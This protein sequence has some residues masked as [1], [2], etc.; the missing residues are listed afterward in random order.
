M[1]ENFVG[2]KEESQTT[3]WGRLNVAENYRSDDLLETDK[4]FNFCERQNDSA[5]T[6]KSPALTFSTPWYW[7]GLCLY[8]D[9]GS[10]GK[11]VE[12]NVL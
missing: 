3:M 10:Q 11:S 5:L 6:K 8:Y 4:Y 1:E 7:Q 12:I 9:T 2:C